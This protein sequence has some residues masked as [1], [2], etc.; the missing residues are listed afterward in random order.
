M[1]RSTLGAI[2]VLV[3]G[4]AASAGI[5]ATG[6]GVV[7]TAAPA[8]SRPNAFA[9]TVIHAWD[10]RQGVELE[11]SL[12]V[13]AM[14]PGTYNGQVDLTPGAILSGTI[15]SSHYIH[16]DSPGALVMSQN[17][18]VRF[19]APILGVIVLGDG[20][21]ADHLD[22]TDFLGAPGTIYPDAFKYRGLD[23]PGDLDT[24]TI[25][26]DRMTLIIDQL[27][28]ANPGDHV[29]IITETIPTPG[30]IALAGLGGL[31]AMSRRRR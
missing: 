9:D 20:E 3:A 5:V 19:D 7:H 14:Q 28:I 6:G 24:F 16:F 11:T 27:R 18:W 4:T 23:F 26:E 8:D 13:D 29:R 21:G 1:A 30:T 2:V 22:S 10:E 25:S 15:V 12:L 31:L 17:G